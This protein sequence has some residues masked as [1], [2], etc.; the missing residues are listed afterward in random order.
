MG[1]NGPVYYNKADATLG[2]QGGSVWVAP[3]SDVQHVQNRAGVVFSTGRAPG[4]TTSYLKGEPIFGIAVPR[5]AISLRLP[6]AGDQGANVH[7]RLGGY[8][9]VQ[10][11]NGLWINSGVRE[12]VIE[13][14]TKMPRGSIFFEFLPDGTY[15]LIRRW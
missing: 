12:F 5:S 2:R 11:N 1:K 4:P 10:Q 6:G 8:T 3:L 7:F 15:L 14:G 13:G 9:G